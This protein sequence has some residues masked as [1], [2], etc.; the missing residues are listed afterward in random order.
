MIGPIEQENRWNA[1]QFRAER[2][3]ILSHIESNKIPGIVWASSDFH[4]GGV[5]RVGPRGKLAH[6]Q[7][8]FLSGPG[9]SKIN[10]W[11]R[12]KL[13]WITKIFQQH[14]RQF[15]KHVATWSY[16]R[17]TLEPPR[18]RV[19]IEFI[20]NDGQV[21]YRTVLD[22]STINTVVVQEEVPDVFDNAT[23]DDDDDIVGD[24]NNS[25]ATFCP[26]IM[27][28]IISLFNFFFVL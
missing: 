19:H 14:S 3:E 13:N 5:Y 4:F 21:L 24:P 7:F 9:G 6:S 11:F 2:T 1:P 20:D 23:S 16:S 26:S 22:V 25:A 18:K 27:M 8:E 15:L 28:L 10:P 12:Y 17:V